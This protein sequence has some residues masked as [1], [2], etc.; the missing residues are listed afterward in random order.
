MFKILKRR[1][2]RKLTLSEKKILDD[3]VDTAIKEIN[4]T[5]LEPSEKFN[6]RTMITEFIILQLYL[7]AVACLIRDGKDKGKAYDLQQFRAEFM[8]FADKKI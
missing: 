6:K 4:P 8:A 7:N 2:E 3:F 5:P 1:K